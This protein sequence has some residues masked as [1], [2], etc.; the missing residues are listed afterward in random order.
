MTAAERA[1]L[2]ADLDAFARRLR[3][4][5][6]RDSDLAVLRAAQHIRDAGAELDIEVT[7]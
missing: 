4:L 1:A 6:D 5:A 7:A 2:A 3:L